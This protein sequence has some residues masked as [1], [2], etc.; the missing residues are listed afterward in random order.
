[1]RETQAYRSSGLGERWNLV[2]EI[3]PASVGVIG[4]RI[5]PPAGSNLTSAH[6][7]ALVAADGTPRQSA[8][9]WP[10]SNIFVTAPDTQ[11]IAVVV[12]LSLE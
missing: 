7:S 12:Q 4:L 6:A 5:D 1:M 10:I 9:G 8:G 3:V 2:Y 11:P